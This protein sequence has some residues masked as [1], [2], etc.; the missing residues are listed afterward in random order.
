MMKA[1]IV[2]LAALV[3]ASQVITAPDN[4]VATQQEQDEEIFE[5]FCRQDRCS[6][7]LW[8]AFAG[9]RQ[10][11]LKFCDATDKPDLAP[12]SMVP[13]TRLGERAAGEC[14]DHPRYKDS[15]KCLMTDT[16]C[17]EDNECYRG[18]YNELKGDLG[19]V[20]DFCLATLRE[21]P[22]RPREP[23]EAMQGLEG[24]CKNAQ[25]LVEACQCAYGGSPWAV[26]GAT[27]CGKCFLAID[28]AKGPIVGNIYHYC[29]EARRELRGVDK[30]GPA[31]EGL[32]VPSELTAGCHSARDINSACGCIVRDDDLWVHPKCAN[33]ACYRFIDLASGD[34]R[35][36]CKTWHRAK[37]FPG[38]ID[39][40][41]IL[42]LEE[43]CPHDADIQEACECI[44]PGLGP[45]WDVPH[46]SHMKCYRIL[47]QEYIGYSHGIRVRCNAH[48]SPRH[49]RRPREAVRDG[50]GRLGAFDQVCGCVSPAEHFGISKKQ[51]NMT[52]L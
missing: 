32:Q 23:K 38:E 2:Y 30:G 27:H 31:F 7:R 52:G 47:D 45:G 48:T 26:T 33:S 29:R 13:K 15:C 12:W 9:H 39:S 10:S 34:T 42:G 36:F 19:N 25:E 17:E 22:F 51:T 24:S 8:N 40:P 44:A 14:L 49:S 37:Q 11:Y 35:N 43:K 28:R 20:S 1:G 21:V 46:C 41:G 6:E 18:I 3:A 4:A 16:G 50:C 5:R